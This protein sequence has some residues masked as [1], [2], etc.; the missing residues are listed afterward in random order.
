MAI[1]RQKEA[2]SRDYALLLFRMSSRVLYTAQYHRQ[3]CTPHAFEQFGALQMHSH[4]D[5]YPS[6]PGFEPG[7]SRLQAPVD[8]N[9][10]SG[11]AQIKIEYWTSQ[12]ETCSRTSMYKPNGKSH[13]LAAFKM[14]Y[15][16]V[17]VR[18][19][20]HFCVHTP[21]VCVGRPSRCVGIPS[22][23]AVSVNTPSPSVAIASDRLHSWAPVSERS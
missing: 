13:V 23:R 22:G 1:S 16:H 5:K 15:E 3:P 19:L 18:G 4:N 12:C 10:P 20:S 21:S 17:D 11:P 14:S 9:E 2:R 7:S 6:R 8:T